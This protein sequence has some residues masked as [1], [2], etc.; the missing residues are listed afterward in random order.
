MKKPAARRKDR[1]SRSRSAD[2]V[3]KP[4]TAERRFD[5]DAWEPSLLA[6]MTGKRRPSGN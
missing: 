3:R 5:V 2:K 6:R 1:S 4:R